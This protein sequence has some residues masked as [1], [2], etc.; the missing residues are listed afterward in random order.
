MS[1]GWRKWRIASDEGE[2]K[3]PAKKHSTGTT[4]P[5]K[6]YLVWLLKAIEIT[7]RLAHIPLYNSRQAVTFTG[8]KVHLAAQAHHHGASEVYENRYPML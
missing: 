8:L 2:C 7:L 4:V 3:I 1:D 5:T 6:G